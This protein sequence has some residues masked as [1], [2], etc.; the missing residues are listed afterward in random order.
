[1]AESE[2]SCAVYGMPRA[3]VEGGLASAVWDLAE[4]AAELCLLAGELPAEEG[5]D[6]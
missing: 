6:R 1:M 4:I 3:I 5:A 2:S